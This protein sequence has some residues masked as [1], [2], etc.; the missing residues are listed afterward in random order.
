MLAFGTRTS[1]GSQVDRAEQ[2]SLPT[3]NAAATRSANPAPSGETY[4]S[5]PP[6]HLPVLATLGVWLVVVGWVG[7][8]LSAPVRVAEGL[9]MA[10]TEM[11]IGLTLAAAGGAMVALAFS[12]ST[13]GEGNA[14]M[15]ARGVLGA[16]VAVSA[17]LPFMPFWAAL[18]TGAAAG[19]LVPLGQ[20][21]VEH[22]LRLDDPTSAVATHGLSALWG[23]L[24]VGLFAD[25]HAGQGWNQIGTGTYLSVGGQ[26]VTGYLAA[27]GYVTDW[28]GQ[29]Q[30]QA[31][32][33]MAIFLTAFFLSWLLYAA[34]QGL[35]RAWQGEYTV[36]LPRRP[37]RKRARQRTAVRHWPR[38]RFVRAKEPE[39]KAE[40]PG[41]AVEAGSRPRSVALKAWGQR[42]VERLRPLAKKRRRAPRKGQGQSG[43]VRDRPE[44]EGT[45][46]SGGD[47]SEQPSDSHP[48]H[49]S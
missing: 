19:L 34:I 5:M 30:A 43:S 47:Q 14:L 41:V 16:V 42:I 20:Y 22:V 6:L 44:I 36:R 31:T 9:E 10:W 38:I 7:W 4:V 46:G 2:L 13:T 40:G 21:L 11:L 17:G 33:A 15:T 25:G 18:A 1:L 49:R 12:W 26:G 3:L 28:P 23:L 35:T 8:G 24:A 32:G 45:L 39:P 48:D 29:F 37:R 27:P